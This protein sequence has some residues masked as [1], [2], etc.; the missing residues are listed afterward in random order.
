MMVDG[1]AARALAEIACERWAPAAACQ[2]QPAEPQGDPWPQTIGPDFTDVEI[3][4]A[5][6]QPR[7]HS[8]DEVRECEALFLD[9]ID[10]AERTIYIENQFVTSEPVARRL[11]RRLR[12]RR[13]LEVLIVAPRQHEFMGRIEDDA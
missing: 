4:I 6:T 2:P 12:E 13:K 3:G 11:A 5:R 10:A 1:D 8:R 9:F 7:Y